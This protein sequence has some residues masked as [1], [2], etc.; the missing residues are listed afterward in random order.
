VD[1]IMT[2]GALIFLAPAVIALAPEGGAGAALLS[3]T[4]SAGVGAL[5]NPRDPAAGVFAG[6]VAGAITGPIGGTSLATFKAMLASGVSQLM[7]TG[8]ID[9][10]KVAAAGIAGGAATFQG[11]AANAAGLGRKTGVLLE[12]LNA[13]FVD[14]LV[15]PD[16]QS[17]T[18][19]KRTL[20]PCAQEPKRCSESTLK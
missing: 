19:K 4:L 20:D 18:P 2:A 9:T 14:L 6:G 16:D 15:K 11:V 12:Q 13:A 1:E 7:L 5:S 10:Q 8:Q 17:S 3:Y